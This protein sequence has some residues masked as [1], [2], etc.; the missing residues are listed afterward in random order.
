MRS[1]VT[2]MFDKKSTYVAFFYLF[3]EY[4]YIYTHTY[5]YMY[6]LIFICVILLFSEGLMVI[7]MIF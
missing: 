4:I 3:L 7:G 6:I 1:F 5:M 2:I